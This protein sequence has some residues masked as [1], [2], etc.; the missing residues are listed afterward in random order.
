MLSQKEEFL[1]KRPMLN[2]LQSSLAGVLPLLAA[3]TLHAQT[4]IPTGRDVE[5]IAPSP[6]TRSDARV[7]DFNIPA[8]RGQIT[9]RY[10]YP[11]ALNRLGYNLEM[12]FPVGRKLT[13]AEAVNFVRR[14]LLNLRSLAGLEIR[15]KESV[16]VKHIQNRPQLPLLLS[17]DVDEEKIKLIQKNKPPYLNIVPVYYRTYPNGHV[18][19]HVIGYVGRMRSRVLGPPEAQEPLWSK[20]EGTEGIERAFDEV[21]SG[22]DGR[23]KITTGADGKITSEGITQ[24]PHPG[25]NVITSLDLEMQKKAEETLAKDAKRGAIVVMDPHTGDVLALASW[26]SYDLNMW[27]P[28]IPTEKFL[29][30]NDDKDKPLLPRA[31]RSAYPP[32]STFKIITGIAAME[33]GKIEADSSFGCPAGIQVGN[34]Y[35]RNHKTSDQG[36]M[37]FISALAASCN[38]WFYQVGIK[39]GG[40]N[41]VAWAM[42]F[43]LGQPSGLPITA[44]SPGRVPTNEYMLKVHKRRILDGDSANISIGQGDLLTTPLQMATAMCGVANGTVLYQPRLVM[45]VQTMDDKV[46]VPYRPR[47]RTVLGMGQDTVDLVHKAMLKVTE[48]GTGGRAK[49]EGFKI[50]GKTGTAQWGPEE[51]EQRIAWFV[52]YAPADNPQYAFCAMYEGDP[53]EKVAGGA[54]AAP[55]NAAVGTIP[56]AIPVATPIES[57]G[58]ISALPTPDAMPQGDPS[59][60]LSTPTILPAIPVNPGQ[61]PRAVPVDP[62]MQVPQALPAPDEMP[63]DPVPY[64]PG[65]GR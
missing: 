19:A 5:T 16:V 57:A 2:R 43:G 24:L 12:R 48:G 28:N 26:P 35:F 29:A 53:H 13:N 36:S 7:Y 47:V 60:G 31:F 18:A 22:V 59:T 55:V 25:F 64:P 41:V 9:D 32:G 4:G 63:V 61:I 58:E 34:H 30:L 1:F 51:L 40:E 37:N 17:R 11:L 42:K 49:V 10:G 38:T 8:P 62:A 27:V 54:K 20:A 39:T 15:V 65:Y 52:G 6:Y 45:Q 33:N 56:Q 14:E 23:L 44:E 50:A 46:E 21:L 3:A